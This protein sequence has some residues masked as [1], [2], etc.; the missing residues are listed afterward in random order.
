MQYSH[1]ERHIPDVRRSVR[2]L[3]LSRTPSNIELMAAGQLGGQLYPTA[4]AGPAGGR[5]KLGSAVENGAINRSFGAAI[6]QWNMHNYDIA[7]ELFRQ[8]IT[9]TPESPWV[10]EAML[11]IGCDARYN[12]R[13]S[14]AEAIFNDIITL[15]KGNAHYG[16]KML[17]NKAQS[18]LGVL[19]MLQGDFSSS[20]KHFT[21]LKNESP[22]WRHRT[23]A[24]HW[25]QRLSRYSQDELSMLTCGT[26]ALARILQDIGRPEDARKVLDIQPS[27][28][29]GHSIDELQQI[30][31][32]YGYQMEGLKLKLADLDLITLPAIIQINRKGIESKG[33][34]WVLEN[35]EN[36]KLQLYDAQSGRQYHQSRDEF[37]REWDGNA[38]VFA[39]SDNLPGRLLTQE[40][41]KEIYGAC[42]GSPRPESNLGQP[43]GFASATGDT[44]CSKGTPK[45][46]VNM[47]NMNLHLSDIPLWHTPAIGPPVYIQLNYNSQS[48][49]ARNEPFGNKWMFSYASYAVEDTGGSVTIFMPDGRRDVFT[50]ID[51]STYEK[52]SGIIN[53][54][55]KIA[56]RH[57]HL[58]LP[59]GTIYAYTVPQGTDSLQ[60]FLTSISDKYGQKLRFTYNGDA[61]INS[62][63]DATGKITSLIDS[64]ND[65]LIDRVNDPHGRSAFFLYD[66]DRNLIRITDMGGYWS[67]LSYDDDIYITELRNSDASWLFNIEPSDA[68]NN[69]AD[70]YPPPGGTMWENY[71]ITVTD[72]LNGKKEFYYN[73]DALQSWIINPR[74]YIEYY[75]PENNNY[76]HAPK[77]LYTLSRSY[78]QG[79]VIFITSPEGSFLNISYDQESGYVSSVADNHNHIS[80][81]TYNSDGTVSAY[82]EPAGN[83]I[84]FE[85]YPDTRNVSTIKY[86][87]QSTPEDD[88]IVLSSFSYNAMTNAVTAITDRTGN[89]TELLYNEYGKVLS[90][91]EAS[92][93]SSEINTSVLYDPLTHWP[94]TL[95]QN[96]L[97]SA[98]YIYDNTGR[99][100]TKNRDGTAL[101]Y[102]YDNLDRV[103]QIVYP[104]NRK[105]S[106]SYSPCCPWLIESTTDLAGTETEFRYDKL[107]RLMEVRGPGGAM[108]YLYDRN[109][110]LEE[111]RQP[112]RSVALF[113]YNLDNRLLSKTYNDGSS[114]SYAYDTAGIKKSSTNARAISKHYTYDPNHNL[115]G[116]TYSDNTPNLIFTYDDYNRLT[117]ESNA[118]GTYAYGYNASGQFSSADGPLDNDKISFNYDIHGRLK[119]LLSETGNGVYFSYD[120]E[121]A[122]KRPLGRIFSI[123]SGEETYTYTYAEDTNQINSLSLPN[124][125][126]TYYQ[127]DD[128]LHRLTEIRTEDSSNNILNR[129]AYSY[130]NFDLISSQTTSAATPPVAYTDGFE[131]SSYN[132]MNELLSTDDQAEYRYDADGNM[133]HGYTATGEIMHMTYDAENRLTSTA[134]TGADNI[135]YKTEYIYGAGNTVTRL[136]K[137]ENSTLVSDIH[138]TRTGLLPLW[139]R[140]A[141]NNVTR[142]YT[143]GLDMAGGI[144]GLLNMNENGENYYYH[145]DGSGNVNTITNSSENIAASYSY[146]IFGKVNAKSGTLDQHFQ[147]S[148]KRHDEETGLS[149]YG[150]RFYSPALGRWL[151]RDPLGEAGGMN[152]YRFVGNNP[153]N[154][155]DP[156]GRLAAPWHFGITYA[157]SRNSGRGVWDSTKLAWTAM[158]VDFSSGSQGENWEATRLHAMAGLLSDGTYQS[159]QQAIQT[160]TAYIN[161]RAGGCGSGALSR[162]AHATQDLATPGH[163]GAEWHGFGLNWETVKHIYG[164]VFPS[165]S[166]INQAYQNT[167][168]VF[169]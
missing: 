131:L 97:E 143:W 43:S 38:L 39:K 79:K 24:A 1:A 78:Q 74:E 23:Y 20:M 91:T 89:T 36:N 94:I 147:F 69:G 53:T 16:S 40:E 92:G 26:D 18:R 2:P 118:A 137:Y 35:I 109:N 157:A 47:I 150:Y 168:G 21:N 127:Y 37:Q 100:I 14:E 139:E 59:D 98:S 107:Q 96:G 76:T 45:W 113:K 80:R 56:E 88:A 66:N 71:R 19:K 30:A 151:N 169:K 77:T 120:Y 160:T 110:N 75:G 29:S 145:Y 108:Q 49:I 101:Q 54:L 81:F 86:N 149:Y 82:T 164:D 52:P 73:G 165:M 115:K 32:Q 128:P 146:D 166:T 55:N 61:V 132:N 133:T 44:E 104:D 117:A 125:T 68:I 154:W 135:L 126:T 58:S 167:D 10:S 27:S 153:V 111:I 162:A 62:I 161:D 93:S 11:H 158:A 5:S 106:L 46:D 6:Q 99:I 34:Y 87:M 156:W 67:E 134:Y 48:G 140:D 13:Y 129:H 41:M 83:K 124:A 70:P 102:S 60:P 7:V 141:I 28:L 17:L 159:S 142:S 22:D 112:G 123:N 148:T 57:Y 33:H 51:Q 64:N 155:I 65:G 42:C 15:N 72:P 152:L 31:L 103:R 144:G 119:E 114:V 4:S 116:I 105:I 9:A 63:V 3:D 122:G 25:L 163:A 50:P 95:K 138:I 136:K 8:H 84:T 12:G 85:Y 121:S 90:I 130:N